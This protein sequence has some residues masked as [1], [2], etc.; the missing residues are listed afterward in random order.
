MGLWLNSRLNFEQLIL[1]RLQYNKMSRHDWISHVFY[2]CF[3][4]KHPPDTVLH[5]DAKL[6]L[7]EREQSSG[8]DST[9]ALF[10]LP[11]TCPLATSWK[12]AGA[13]CIRHRLHRPLPAAPWSW[14]LIF[15]FIVVLNCKFADNCFRCYLVFHRTFEFVFLFSTIF[16]IFSYI[17]PFNSFRNVKPYIFEWNECSPT[18]FHIYNCAFNWFFFFLKYLSSSCII[19]VHF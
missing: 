2:F 3:A 1:S 10:R 9:W 13:G 12:V 19:C 6:A 4:V 14:C 11:P 5:E 8:A 18:H 7:Q 16:I 17:F 15:L